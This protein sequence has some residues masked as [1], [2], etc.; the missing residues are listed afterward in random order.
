MLILNS[1]RIQRLRTQG[2]ISVRTSV[3][4]EFVIMDPEPNRPSID[5]GTEDTKE[6]K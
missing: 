3:P 5:E 6:K 4:G 1:I 2:A